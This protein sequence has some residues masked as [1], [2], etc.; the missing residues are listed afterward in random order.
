[1]P[2]CQ[3]PGP[4][5][6]QEKTDTPRKDRGKFFSAPGLPC[7]EIPFLDEA[8]QAEKRAQPRRMVPD[9]PSRGGEL[10]A[11]LSSASIMLRP[12]TPDLAR[13]GERAGGRRSGAGGE[14]AGCPGARPAA[15]EARCRGPVPAPGPQRHSSTTSAKSSSFGSSDGSSVVVSVFS[16]SDTEDTCRTQSL[17]LSGFG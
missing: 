14:R 8:V 9:N 16:V 12:P 17:S 10:R 5:P 15:S 2:K 11:G 4:Q 7:S 6:S 1:M 3:E 13:R